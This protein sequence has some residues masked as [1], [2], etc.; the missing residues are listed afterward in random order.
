[1][2]KSIINERINKVVYLEKPS[3]DSGSYLKTVVKERFLIRKTANPVAIIKDTS[4]H[5]QTIF[6]F[7]V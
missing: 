3:K 4:V 7:S 6:S 1:M 5:N 2:N